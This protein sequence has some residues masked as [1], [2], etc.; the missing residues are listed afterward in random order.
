MSYLCGPLTKAQIKQLM[1]GQVATSEAAPKARTSQRLTEADSSQQPGL[2]AD[3]PQFFIPVTKGVK[4]SRTLYRPHIWGRAKIQFIDNR[5]KIDT[6]HDV[7]LIVP[8]EDSAIPVEW[9]NSIAVDVEGEQ[10]S[11]TPE[12]DAAYDKVPGA[13]TQAKNYA[14]WKNDYKN[15]LD[16]SYKITLFKSPRLGAISAPDE[17]ERD[18]RI[19]LTQTAREKRDESTTQLQAKYASR[20]AAL[21]NK[22]RVAEERAAREKAQAN[23]QKFNTA[24]SIGT[25]LLGAFLGRKAISSS[26]ISRAGNAVRTATRAGKES[27]DAARAEESLESLQAQLA[28]LQQEFQTELDSY[29]DKFDAQKEELETIALR[30][31]HTSIQLVSFV[32]VPYYEKTD[33]TIEMACS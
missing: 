28:E 26:T 6:A 20:I 2:P 31:S 15:F 1:A 19:R 24:I 21:Q 33:G 3:I 10:L 5:N 9:T 27:G 25:T 22:I 14:T 4:A 7:R 32:W 13:A 12:K 11:R 29:G 30:P 8:V 23:Q 18:F 17:A 16:S